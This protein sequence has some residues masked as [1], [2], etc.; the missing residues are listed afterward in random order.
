MLF[1]LSLA[2]CATKKDVLYFQDYAN[3]GSPE[4][5]YQQ[6][7]IQPND[8]L[9][10]KISTIVPEAALAYNKPL[11]PMGGMQSLDLL[12]LQGYLVN[13]EGMVNLPVLGA[14]KLSG[15]TTTVAENKVKL[16][17]E[18]AGHLQ[19]PSVSI[20]LLNG[21]ISILGEVNK[22]G[23]ITFTEQFLTIPQAL[24]YAGDLTIN[25][26]RGDILL[27]RESNGKRQVFRLDLTKTNWLNNPDYLLRQNDVLVV[28]PNYARTK[29]A[30][31]FGSSSNVLTILSLIL[32]TY[33][34]I[35]R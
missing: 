17:L 21:K 19:N 26:Q 9:D 18:S 24:G 35:T 5:M 14:V 6:S 25:G 10:I 34:V 4:I 15:L 8:I 23:T 31:F 7:T 27:L 1:L 16:L 11:N 12:Q 30:G 29:S 2:S 13:L 3:F 22:P 20:R 32:S 28:N 33:I